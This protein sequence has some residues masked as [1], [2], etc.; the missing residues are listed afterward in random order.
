MS[1][2]IDGTTSHHLTGCHPTT[3]AACLPACLPAYLV[4]D[5][6]GLGE[7]RV[8]PRARQV[9]PQR[10]V[11]RHLLPVQLV[12]ARQAVLHIP[13][14]RL[15]LHLL[16]LVR[17][18][19]LRRRRRR[20][21]RALG[22][23]RQ[24]RRGAHEPGLLQARLGLE[25]EEA[26]HVALLRQALD[27]RRHG[28]AVLGQPPQLAVRLAQVLL[29]RRRDERARPHPRSEGGPPLLQP[30]LLLLKAVRHGQELAVPLL[31]LLHVAEH[32]N[33]RAPRRRRRRRRRQGQDALPRLRSSLLHPLVEQELDLPPHVLH[34]LVVAPLLAQQLLALLRGRAV[35]FGFRGKGSVSVPRHPS[36]MFMMRGLADLCQR[37]ELPLADLQVPR[38]A[39][40]L[41]HHLFC[42]C[43]VVGVSGSEGKKIGP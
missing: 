42:V 32:H 27:G 40:Q 31:Q 19:L 16:G 7:R 41:R 29:E 12:H 15:Q 10:V 13:Q 22:L 20:G 2:A 6:V 17:R 14:L 26:D 9:P 37:L 4:E 11:G 28:L 8:L 33:V 23:R 21:P 25:Q 18:R 36:H 5:R 39:V 30:A 1:Q 24:G 43:V 34:Q 35:V 38:H 3:Q